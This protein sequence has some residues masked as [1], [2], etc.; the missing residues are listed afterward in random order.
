MSVVDIGPV[1]AGPGAPATTCSG[2]TACCC[3]CLEAGEAARPADRPVPRPRRPVPRP[4]G[5]RLREADRERPRDVVAVGDEGPDR[6]D[7]ARDEERVERMASQRGRPGEAP[8]SW[9]QTGSEKKRRKRARNA[10]S[11][12]V[13]ACLASGGRHHHHLAGIFLADPGAFFMPT[14]EQELS[15]TL[16]LPRA[17]ARPFARMPWSIALIVRL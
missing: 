5:E 16:R 12:S 14:R 1:G 8:G 13:V 10:R 9:W 3:R 6:G 2:S 7:R 4:A 11:G 17:R 15:K